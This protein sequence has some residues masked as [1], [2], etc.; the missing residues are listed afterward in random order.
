MPEYID[1]EAGQSALDAAYKSLLEANAALLEKGG[2]QPII[3][4]AA[5]MIGVGIDLIGNLVAWL[6]D[7]HNDGPV[8]RE[9]GV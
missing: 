2:M 9:N 6:E 5:S 3:G 4:H 8:E 1:Y 7:A